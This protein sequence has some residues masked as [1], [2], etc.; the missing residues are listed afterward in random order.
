MPSGRSAVIVAAGASCCAPFHAVR[1]A[2]F[3]LLTLSPKSRII[4]I[5]ACPMENAGAVV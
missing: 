3:Y 4:I 5:F 1:V 2:K